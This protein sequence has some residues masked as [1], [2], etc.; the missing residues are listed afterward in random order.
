[1]N[2]STSSFNANAIDQLHAQFLELV[3]RLETHA[4]IYFRGIQCP[5]KKADKVSE[6]IAL[7]WQWYI[8]LCEKGKDITQFSMVFVY[9]VAKAVKSGRRI[10]GQEKAKDVLSSLA[11]QRHNFLVQS[12]PAATRVAHENLYGEPQRQRQQDAYE[13]RLKD[14]LVT[15]IPDQVQFRIDFPAWLATLTPRERRLIRAMALNERTSDLS[16]EFELSPGRISQLRREFQQSWRR[17]IGE[18]EA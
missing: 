13:E 2:A 1:L 6:T 10:C 11:Q 17:Y 9:L 18:G 3:P 4:E 15:P 5:D 12:L 8:R 16:K 14:N 7:A